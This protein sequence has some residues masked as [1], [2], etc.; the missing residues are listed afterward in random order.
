MIFSVCIESVILQN[1]PQAIARA[2][3]HFYLSLIFPLLM[4][5]DD[6]PHWIQSTRYPEISGELPVVGDIYMYVSYISLWANLVPKLVI[7]KFLIMQNKLLLVGALFRL[8]FFSKYCVYCH[9]MKMQE[10]KIQA[11]WLFCVLWAKT[12][13]SVLA[14]L[15]RNTVFVAGSVECSS[16]E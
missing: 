10:V 12:V 5:R 4:E 3:F 9:C 7:L 6:C 8:N 14:C 11:S 16:L 2:F 1:F 13:S 15:P